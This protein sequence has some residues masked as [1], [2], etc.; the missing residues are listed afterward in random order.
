MLRSFFRWARRRRLVLVDPTGGLWRNSNS[1]FSG[2][3]LS[4]PDQ[5]RLFR[6]WTEGTQVD[7]REAFVGLM[8]LLHGATQHE[9][10]SLTVDDVDRPQRAVRLGRRS[11]PLVLDPQTGPPSTAA[12]PTATSCVPSTRTYS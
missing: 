11:H 2:D 9:L 4:L 5:R 1:R 12:S 3:T 7:P 8:V 6:R 10:R